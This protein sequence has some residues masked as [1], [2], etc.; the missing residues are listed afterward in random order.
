MKGDKLSGFSAKWGKDSDRDLCHRVERND[1]LR[2]AVAGSGA[3]GHVSGPGPADAAA[4]YACAPGIAG[5]PRR[6]NID[7]E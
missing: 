7:A 5:S 6:R 1:W 4:V 2:H 3:A